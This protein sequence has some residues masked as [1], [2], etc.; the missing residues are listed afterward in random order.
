MVISS[1]SLTLVSALGSSQSDYVVNGW[2]LKVTLVPEKSEIMAG[3]PVFLAYQVENLS[4]TNLS[5]L[6]GG[7]YRNRL[8]RPE[9]FTVTIRS[10]EG[11]SLPVPDPGPSFGGL[12]GAQPLPA[13]GKFG[14]AL[15]L[16]DWGV[17]TSPGVYSI[18]A[19]RTLNL[20]PEGSKWNYGASTYDIST[21]VDCSIKVVPADHQRM[22]ELIDRLGKDLLAGK[23]GSMQKL[24]AISDERTIPYFRQAAES[25]DYELKV[26]ALAALGKFGSEEAIKVL[27]KGLATTWQ[28]IGN[29]K[30][31]HQAESMAE[32]I[33]TAAAQALQCSQAEKSHQVLI[34][35]LH[36]SSPQIRLTAVHLLG[37]MK[38]EEAAE[39]LKTMTN[40]SY[41]LVR[42]EAARYLQE[43]SS[44]AATGAATP[45][46]P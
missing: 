19:R 36:D 22:G 26:E 15:F 37:S 44:T 1:L 27:E 11:Q 17:I 7:D 35:H 18:S 14:T 41:A 21:S 45:K 16:S 28:D 6:V 12:G 20:I 31:Q 46:K 30:N 10:A 34:A 13:H 38:T 23:R 25:R 40:D 33:R 2:P 29:C 42:Q 8:G 4:D 24:C 32:N 5:L 9:R 3:E 43:M 39:R